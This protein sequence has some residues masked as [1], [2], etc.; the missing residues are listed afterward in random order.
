MREAA[1]R[2][3]SSSLPMANTNTE[4]FIPPSR[5]LLLY[6]QSYVSSSAILLQNTRRVQLSARTRSHKA[7]NCITIKVS[8]ERIRSFGN[9]Q[10]VRP[11]FNAVCFRLKTRVERHSRAFRRTSL[12]RHQMVE[13][14]YPC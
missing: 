4:C 7:P 5:Y 3:S 8:G 9:K 10:M 6:F 12:D 2:K 11:Q 1:L 13:S 14:R